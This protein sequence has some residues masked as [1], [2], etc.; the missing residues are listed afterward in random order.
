MIDN[1]KIPC[2]VTVKYIREILP[3]GIIRASCHLDTE[4]FP[5]VPRQGLHKLA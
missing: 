5:N 3:F 4:A 1:R 2:V